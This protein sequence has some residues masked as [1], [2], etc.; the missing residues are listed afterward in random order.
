M[1]LYMCMHIEKGRR[2]EWSNPPSQKSFRRTEGYVVIT[3]YMTILRSRIDGRRTFPVRSA[4]HFSRIYMCM[5]IEKGRGV[6]WSKPPFPE[7]F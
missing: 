6:E 2:V 4:P 1:S 5:H 7:K 3:Y